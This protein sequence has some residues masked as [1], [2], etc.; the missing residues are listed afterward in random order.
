MHSTM[1]IKKI[2][3]DHFSEEEIEV[4]FQIGEMENVRDMLMDSFNDPNCIYTEKCLFLYNGISL[5]MKG[6][7]VPKVVKGLTEKG[8]QIYSV[9][10]PY[11]P[12]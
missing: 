5:R 3:M 7:D 6:A 10:Q 12:Y 4:Y 9:Y 1:L 11:K 8:I 2:N